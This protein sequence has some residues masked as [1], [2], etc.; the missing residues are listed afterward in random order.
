[1]YNASIGPDGG[2]SAGR[3]SIEHGD[4]RIGVAVAARVS[5]SRDHGIQSSCESSVARFNAIK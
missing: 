3:S 1:L 2:L 5:S 4:V